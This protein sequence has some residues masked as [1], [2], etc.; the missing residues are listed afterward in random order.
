M[1]FAQMKPALLALLK[2]KSGRSMKRIVEKLSEAEVTNTFPIRR[3]IQGWY[4]RLDETSNGTWL[5]E[6]TDLWGRRVSCQ[7]TDEE[8]LLQGCEAMA[9][10]V[11]RES[12]PNA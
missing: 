3:S 10:S 7:G 6:G 11:V 1:V 4:F 12:Q 5:A 2:F 9:E 8:A